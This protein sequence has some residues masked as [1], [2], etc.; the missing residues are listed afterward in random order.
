M[1]KKNHSCLI[2]CSALLKLHL[3]SFL[4][5]FIP[6]LVSIAGKFSVYTFII[7]VWFMMIEY[8]RQPEHSFLIHLHSTYTQ[9]VLMVLV[10][11]SL[12]VPPDPSVL[13][14]SY[15]GC[16]VCSTQIHLKKG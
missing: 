13:L 12:C 6:K 4:F 5:F 2:V 10:E 9:H 15:H 7:H 1:F 16:L 3:P 14:G 11:D 8:S